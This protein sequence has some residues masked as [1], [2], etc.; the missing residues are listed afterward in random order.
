[1]GL[2]NFATATTTLFSVI[3]IALSADLIAHTEPFY[4]QFSALALATGLLTVFTI[5][6][7]YGRPRG[8]GLPASLNGVFSL[9]I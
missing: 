2:N 4:Y 9:H 8:R 1:L 6:P 7:M 3:V 5:V